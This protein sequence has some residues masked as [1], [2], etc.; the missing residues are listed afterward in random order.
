[1]RFATFQ[2]GQ[3]VGPAIVR[4]D[5]RLLDIAMAGAAAIEANLLSKNAKLPRSVLDI[6]SGG[7]QMFDLCALLEANAN[8]SALAECV[9]PADAV[10]LAPIP[11]PA[12]NV[13]CVGKNY[14]AHISE[15]SV[16]QGIAD[17]VPERPAAHEN[18]RLFCRHMAAAA[19]AE[20]RRQ[21]RD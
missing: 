14:R 19:V 5:D 13:F 2:A 17:V 11:R 18:P 16:A 3:R 21:L 10:L 12:K 4:A 6:V 15:G 8:H 7:A 1:M 9:V 20:L